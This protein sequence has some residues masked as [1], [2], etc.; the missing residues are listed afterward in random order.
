M[1]IDDVV[2]AVSPPCCGIWGTLAVPITNA[3]F[4]GVQL[5]G[6]AIG[7]FTLG[8]LGH[9]LV[10]SKFTVGLRLRRRRSMGPMPQ[11]WASKPIR[12]SV[13]FAKALH[14]ISDGSNASYL[15]AN[16]PPQG[17]LFFVQF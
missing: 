11:N 9:C 7:A 5:T 4:L 14:T 13:A 6:I 2:G 8:N 12:N 10:G 16:D 15:S 1:K 17:G 3:G